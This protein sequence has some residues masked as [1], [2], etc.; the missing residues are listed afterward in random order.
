M[1]LKTI[2]DLPTLGDP[3]YWI[4]RNQERSIKGLKEL[5]AHKLDFYEVLVQ[6]DR[7]LKDV[8]MTVCRILGCR[9]KIFYG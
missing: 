8:L 2:R 6:P 4:K 5:D 1:W 3:L 7:D 9:E